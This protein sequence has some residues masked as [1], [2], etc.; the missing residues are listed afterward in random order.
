MPKRTTDFQRLVYLVRTNL[1]EGA[2]VTESKMLLDRSTG[3]EREVDVCIEGTVG[4][5]PVLVSVECRE[6][7]RVADVSWVESMKAKHERLSTNALIL[8]SSSGFT[9]GARAVATQYGIHTFTL[10]EV[11][12]TDF[13]G[14]FGEASELWIKSV[15]L[16][17]RK[18]TVQVP[19]QGDLPE[20]SVVAVAD[21]V[22]YSADG[23]PLGSIGRFV[24]RMLEAKSTRQEM[25]DK[26]MEEHKSFELRWLQPQSENHPSF[27][28]MKLD[29]E[30]LRQ[31]EAIRVVGSCEF[32]IASFGMRFARLGGIS[33]AWGKTDIHG[34]D[35]MIVATMDPSG[36]ARL[37]INVSGKV[38]GT[39]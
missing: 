7:Q 22:V 20:E 25:L 11:E 26:G 23:T 3:R 36:V 16:T 10:E 38:G 35:T 5:Q 34:R 39:T 15:T 31:I 1:A 19:A 24:E 28:L 18:V 32:K 33:V 14:L 27:Y 17:A 4:G 2:T 21:N 29:P 8:A 9:S 30:T 6:H 13:A 37:S 12:T